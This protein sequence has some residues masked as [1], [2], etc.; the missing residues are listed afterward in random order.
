VY[1]LTA[2]TAPSSTFNNKANHMS[3]LSMA[4]AL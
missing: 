3:F 4:S 1:G 2:G